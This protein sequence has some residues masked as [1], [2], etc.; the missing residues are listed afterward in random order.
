VR[1][2]RR[3]GIALIGIAFV[4]PSSVIADDVHITMRLSHK[5]TGENRRLRIAGQLHLLSEESCHTNRRL[6]VQRKGEE[7][8]GKALKTKTTNDNGRY[9]FTVADRPGRYRVIAPSV[10]LTPC[11]SDKSAVKRHRH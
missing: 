8:W 5:G 1:V 10:L 7:G 2:I 11:E 4:L 9:W 3:V 6:F